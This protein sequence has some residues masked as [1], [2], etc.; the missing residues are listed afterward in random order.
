MWELRYERDGFQVEAALRKNRAT[1]EWYDNE[2]IIEPT[3]IFYI[4]AF[5]DLSTC[6]ISGMGIGYLGQQ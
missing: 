1:P 3:D 5:H 2:P 4:K 6:R